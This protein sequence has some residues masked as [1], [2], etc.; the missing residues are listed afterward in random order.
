MKRSLS[1]LA[2]GILL[3]SSPLFAEESS[4]VPWTL[5]K[6]HSHV[7]FSVRH[8]GI[9]KVRGE[10]TDFSGTFMADPETGKLTH[11]DATV[12]VDSVDTGIEGRDNHLKAED[13][14]AADKFP[15]MRLVTKKIQWRGSD[16]FVATVDLTIRD[17]TH[18]VRFTG[19]FLG[20]HMVAF[21]NGPKHRRA[22]Y[23]ASARI[24]RKKFGLMFNSLAEGVSVVG[25]RVQ[26]ELEVELSAP[27]K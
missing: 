8:L 27:P 6:N 7:G 24:D 11:V 13:F 1:L 19:E 15:Q 21:G 2:A 14:F 16:T 3:A 23:S 22:G 9:S 20:S 4:S 10:F 5:D 12:Q 18:P 26:I 25:D 17:Q